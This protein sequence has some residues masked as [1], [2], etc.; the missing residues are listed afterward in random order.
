M[1]VGVCKEYD[2]RAHH[3]SRHDTFNI[4]FLLHKEA[5]RCKIEAEDLNMRPNS[6]TESDECFL[7]GNLRV[8]AA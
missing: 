2:T 1:D 4:A 7:K 8:H 5:E 6:S 3:M